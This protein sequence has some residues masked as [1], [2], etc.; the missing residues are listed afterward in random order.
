MTGMNN[1]K[2]RKYKVVS[3]FAGCGGADLGFLGGFEFLDHEY[4]PLPFE[5]VWA[6]DIDRYACAVYRANIGDHVQCGDIT[7]IRFNTLGLLFDNI[8]LLLGGFPC[9]EFSLM[10]P[11]RG[12]K[13]PRG[14]LYK[15][16]RRA[17]RYFRP[18]MFW[19]ENV[20]GIEHPPNTLKTIVRGLGGRKSPTYR[21][22]CYHINAA[23]Y[24]VPQIRKRVL[25]MGIRS[26]L[27]DTFIPPQSVYYSPDS[28]RDDKPRWVTALDALGS[29]WD[30]SRV[31][32]HGVPDQEKLTK[33]TICLELGSRRD[34]RLC[35][36]LPATTIRAEHHGHVQVHYNT[37]YNGSLRRLTVRECARIQGFPDTFVF[38]VSATQAYKQIGN[39]I[40]PVLSYHWAISIGNW[41][42]SISLENEKT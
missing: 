42:D 16:M 19:A 17:I 28:A 31:N 7:K 37:L 15:H 12:L 5:I 36:S 35:P 14:T 39:A 20:P 4:S 29:L 27:P 3:L 26:D 10:G 34:H 30:P 21:V 6:N 2:E 24:G 38:P 11:R 40:A 23:D 13:A 18:K 41:L 32:D 8:D 22:R 25:I 33:A 9:Q 1:S